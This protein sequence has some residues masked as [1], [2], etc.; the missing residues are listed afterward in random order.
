MSGGESEGGS[1]S[2]GEGVGSALFSLSLLLLIT[3]PLKYKVPINTQDA[4]HVVMATKAW[5]WGEG[6]HLHPLILPD[7]TKGCLDAPSRSQNAEHLT[8]SLGVPCPEAG[9]AGKSHFPSLASVSPPV[10]QG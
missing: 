7:Q 8:H 2:P 10:S 5:E 3:S 4:G 1:G 6:S 9:Y